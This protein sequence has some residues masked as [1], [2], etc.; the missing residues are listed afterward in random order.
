M[1]DTNTPESRAAIYQKAVKAGQRAVRSAIQNKKNPYLPALEELVP[2]VN[3]L[4]HVALGIH[5]IP[6][7]AIEGSVSPGRT[8]AFACNFMPLLDDDTEFSSK[9]QN[10]YQS[11]VD[12]GMRDPVKVME[13]MNRYFA[14][15][16]NKRISVMKLLDS[17]EIEADVT[18]IFPEK[19]DDKEVRI[20]YEY[21]EFFNDTGIMGLTFSEE[22]SYAHL[23]E[24]AGQTPGVKWSE[25][26]LENFR[27]SYHT[28]SVAYHELE[29][30]T[31]NR[32]TEGD[33]FLIYL[34]AFGYHPDQMLPSII[35]A[36]IVKLRREFRTQAQNEP[37]SLQMT[38]DGQKPNIIQQI[39]RSS[40]PMNVCFI[41][42]RSPEL[43]G[44][45]YWHELGMNH[46]SSVFGKKIKTRMVNDVSPRDCQSVIEQE[47]KAGANIIFTTSP[48]LL[49]GA[50]KAAV[51]LP[52]IKILN[53]SL[54]PVYN[55][56]RSYYLRMYE[57]K[58]IL[59]AIAGAV[60]DNN[61]IGYIA[62]YPVFGM[63]ASVNAFALGARMINPRAKI[64][65]EWSTVK[66]SDPETALAAQN[67]HVICNRDIAAPAFESTVF[68]LYVN[69]G[70]R[71]QN[72]A[73]PVW[74]WGKLYENLLQRIQNGYWD[75]DTA[76]RNDQAMNYWWG[77]D[78]GAIDVYYSKKLDAGTK[79]LTE[80]LRTQVAEGT[81]KPFADTII[82]QDGTIRCNEGER[83]TPPQIIAMD[84]LCDNVI[85][86]IPGPDDLKPEALPFVEMQG[87]RCAK[88]PDT[89][90]IAWAE[91]QK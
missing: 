48:V 30:D 49:D 56:V 76:A 64:Y 59:G 33:A 87:L 39:I 18:R 67:V 26:D 38:P 8:P 7:S 31:L 11:I 52:D 80:L 68:G 43:S 16:G 75:T 51:Q 10:L 86:F 53:C 70:D 28:F 61:R 58:F 88:A 3:Q 17:P 78:M 82:S 29:D 50:I 62:D 65:L 63:P 13:Y 91:P 55:A 25:E 19:T 23:I 83:L 24:I 89:S 42:S 12:D 20:Y 71:T 27:S 15:E 22:G 41:N 21:L 77:M 14:V 46:V 4:S 34:Q 37:I 66:D 2:N 72:L 5:S 85:G 81:L 32:I 6:T 40:G 36:N 35:Q 79:R 60:S 47:V 90:E 45:T 84:W 73:M 9:W 74:H 1:P 44:W 57:A 54:L 69:H